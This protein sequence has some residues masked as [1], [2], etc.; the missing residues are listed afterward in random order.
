[1]KIIVPI[2]PLR[3]QAEPLLAAVAHLVAAGHHVIVTTAAPYAARARAAGARYHPPMPGAERDLSGFGRLYPQRALLP[4]GPLQQRF[5]L[6]RITLAPMAAQYATLCQLLEREDIDL[7]LH[8]NLYAGALPLL[9]GAGPARPA[10]VALGT[11]VMPLP[12]RDGAP[13]GQGLPSPCNT[14]QRTLYDHIVDDTAAR[15]HAPLRLQADAILAQLGAL[16]PELPLLEAIV[17]LPDQYL[18]LGVPG[19]EFAR[20]ARARVP[21]FTGA[22][23]RP[24]PARLPPALDFLS[25]PGRRLILVTQG[26]LSNRDQ[27]QL[28]EPAIA[29][30]ADL[31]D[32]TVLVATG[33]VRPGVLPVEL[34]NNVLLA[35]DLPFA[36]VMPYVDVLVTNGGYGGAMQALSQGVPLVCAGLSEFKAEVALCVQRAGAGIDLMTDAPSPRQIRQAVHALLVDPSYRGRAQDLAQQFERH[37]AAEVLPEVLARLAATREPACKTSLR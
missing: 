2:T 3:S 10:V 22:L 11:T 1:M 32:S 27:G 28:I 7:I 17:T 4:P 16:A 13:I 30:L 37:D 5:D 9:L 29:A 25:M 26:T 8:D 31:P 35:H 18:Q 33:G 12:R 20:H 24:G 36:A 15:M 21:Q 34:P 6:E 19:F 23:P 14:A